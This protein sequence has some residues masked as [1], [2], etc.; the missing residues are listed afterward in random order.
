MNP[1]PHGPSWRSLNRFRD[2]PT[3]ELMIACSDG[4]FARAFEEF[5]TTGLGLDRYA[6]LIVPG[7]PAFLAADDAD[8]WSEGPRGRDLRFIID[9]LSIER[10]H[11]I[12]HDLCAYYE[13]GLGVAP[14]ALADRQRADLALAGDR[15]AASWPSL[16]IHRWRA[17]VEA[18][19]VVVTP[20]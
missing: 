5:A 6:R 8:P 3:A 2:E 9:A 19:A 16:Q 10:V 15:L 1:S 14:A 18:G 17:T 13:Q 20:S 12:Q 7:G 4:R 11:L